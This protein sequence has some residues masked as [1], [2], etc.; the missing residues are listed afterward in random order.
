MDN[1]ERHIQTS[2]QQLEEQVKELVAFFEQGLDYNNM[3]YTYWTAKDVLGHI[4]FWHESFARNIRDVAKGK[5]TNPLKGTLSEV[6]RTSVDSTRSVPI[7]ELLHRIVEAQNIIGKYSKNPMVTTI[8]YKKGSRN[9]TLLE[10]IEVV[11]A[12]INKHLKDIKKKVM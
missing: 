9:Y 2:L 5:K 8:P 6:N 11:Y 4:T 7:K 1:S 10:H 3:V 12:H